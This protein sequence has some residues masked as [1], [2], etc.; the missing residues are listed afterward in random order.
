[1]IAAIPQELVEQV[2]IGAMH[3]DAIETCG[4]G[5]D[6]RLTKPRNDSWQFLIAQFAR[7]DI[8]L[9]ALR[10]M[11]LI[12]GDRERT[13]RHWLRSVIKQRMT[14]TPPMP[15]LQE[16]S[17]PCLMHGISNSPPARD[18]LRRMDARLVPESRIPS[19]GH[20]RLSNQ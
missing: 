11:H 5:I 2:A 10:R 13:R 18:L 4:Q 6:R 15:H 16:N 9:L 14:G 17:P 20:G 12:T 3:F 8:G 1:M 19:H 7:H